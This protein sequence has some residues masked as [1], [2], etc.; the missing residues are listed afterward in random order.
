MH[1]SLLTVYFDKVSKKEMCQLNSLKNQKKEKSISHL[2]VMALP[3]R[4]VAGLSTSSSLS[5]KERINDI[6]RF[7]SFIRVNIII[8]I[9]LVTATFAFTIV[10]FIAIAVITV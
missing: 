8:F 6:T 2:L 10:V 1:L 5:T 9:L 7:V 4:V 3:E